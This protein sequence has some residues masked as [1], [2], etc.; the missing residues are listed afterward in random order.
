MSFAIPKT[1]VRGYGGA[2]NSIAL[3]K[4]ELRKYLP[5][6]DECFSGTI[7]IYLHAPLDVRIPS[8]RR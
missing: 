2:K 7:N 6:I 8:H 4:P 5:Q 3:Q 1:V